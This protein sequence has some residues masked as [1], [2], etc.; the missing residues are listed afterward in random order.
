MLQAGQLLAA[1]AD[2]HAELRSL[3]VELRGL[4]AHGDFHL[5]GHLHEAQQLLEDAACLLQH[6]ALLL[7]ELLERLGGHERRRLPLRAIALRLAILPSLSRAPLASVGPMAAAIAALTPVPS[8]RPTPAA[9][10]AAGSGVRRNLERL[11]GGIGVPEADRSAD[12]LGVGL[13]WLI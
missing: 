8:A 5:G 7:G 6:G 3:D 9:G 12:R 11:A 13:R 1:A 4:G 10:A 2:E